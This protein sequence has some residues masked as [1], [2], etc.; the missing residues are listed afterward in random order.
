MRPFAPGN[1]ACPDA[2]G[3]QV[4]SSDPN[5]ATAIEAAVRRAGRRI[6]ITFS[7]RHF[8]MHLG[9]LGNGHADGELAGLFVA[10]FLRPDRFQPALRDHGAMPA[11]ER[12]DR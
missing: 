5:A 4:A 10:H 12:T 2:T 1:A 7:S 6:V 9:V 3:Q 11:D 8:T